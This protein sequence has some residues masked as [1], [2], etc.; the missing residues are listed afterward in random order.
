LH[1]D[2]HNEGRY[3][4]VCT[5]TD[6]DAWRTDAAPVTVEEV[7]K[8][9]HTNASL[10]KH[11]AASILGA[12]HQAVIAGDVL[13]QAAGGMKWSLMTGHEHVSEEEKYML[14]YILPEY[15]PE[16]HEKGSKAVDT[17]D[18]DDLEKVTG[19]PK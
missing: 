17:E 8:T 9:L 12:V 16:A 11:I 15:F 19:I 2:T 3:A 18:K 5:S 10:S 4:L 14:K 13:T 7:M 6:Y 1:V